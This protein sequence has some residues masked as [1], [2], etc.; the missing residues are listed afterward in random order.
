MIR[1]RVTKFYFIAKVGSQ[2][3]SRKSEETPKT[4]AKEFEIMLQTSEGELRHHIRVWLYE[5]IKID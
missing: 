5:E 3:S 2:P 4:I 1:K